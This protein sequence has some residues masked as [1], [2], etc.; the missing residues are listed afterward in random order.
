MHQQKDRCPLQV[1]GGDSALPADTGKRWQKGGPQPAASH[2]RAS[3][4][5]ELWQW[6]LWGLRERRESHK[7]LP[8]ATKRSTRHSCLVCTSIQ[9][10]GP[11]ADTVCLVDPGVPLPATQ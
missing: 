10:G 2:L 1:M 4:E 5:D 3:R 9:G 8:F 11:R 6:S 7:I